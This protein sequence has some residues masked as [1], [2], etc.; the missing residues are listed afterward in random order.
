VMRWKETFR[1][2]PTIGRRNSRVTAQVSLSKEIKRRQSAEGGNDEISP[3]KLRSPGRRPI[4]MDAPLPIPRARQ[5]ADIE[6]SV[7]RLSRPRAIDL[8]A[9]AVDAWLVEDDNL[10]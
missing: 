10:R 6:S 3:R 5:L 2:D 4:H 1:S 7:S 8:V 9:A